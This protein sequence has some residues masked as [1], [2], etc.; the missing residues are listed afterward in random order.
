MNRPD[1]IHIILQYYQAFVH[2][3]LPTERYFKLHIILLCVYSSI[4]L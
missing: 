2:Q 1:L 4:V 3:N